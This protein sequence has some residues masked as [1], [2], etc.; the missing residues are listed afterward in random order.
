V[1]EGAILEISRKVPGCAA[2]KQAL[3]AGLEEA[4][5]RTRYADKA[6]ALRDA[7]DGM[8]DVIERKLRDTN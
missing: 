6:W 7:F 3:H 1:Y 8:L 2:P 4:S 5:T